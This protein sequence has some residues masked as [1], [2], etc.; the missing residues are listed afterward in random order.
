MPIYWF[1]MVIYWCNM[2]IYQYN[3]GIYQCN[4]AIYWCSIT[5]QTLAYY[6]STI[7]ILLYSTV[8]KQ[9]TTELLVENYQAP[10]S[11]TFRPFLCKQRAAAFFTLLR[12]AALTAENG[13]SDFLHVTDCFLI[14]RFFMTANYKGPSSV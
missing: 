6:Y 14:W 12:A 4:I 1:I 8:V 10:I 7:L 2:A 13:S 9:R 11:T 3:M 5:Y